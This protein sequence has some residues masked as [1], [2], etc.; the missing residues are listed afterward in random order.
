MSNFTLIFS[1]NGTSIPL[2]FREKS[3]LFL[4]YN[5]YVLNNFKKSSL[6]NYLIS[7]ILIIF[8]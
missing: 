7:I 1:S 8:A 3:I 6:F 4:I 2:I 5:N